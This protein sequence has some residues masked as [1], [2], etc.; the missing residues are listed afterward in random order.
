MNDAYRTMLHS[1]IERREEDTIHGN[2]RTVRVDDVLLKNDIASNREFAQP[3]RASG[4]EDVLWKRE[5]MLSTKPIDVAGLPAVCRRCET[6]YCAEHVLPILQQLRGR[7]Q[8]FKYLWCAN[9]SLI[10]AN[11]NHEILNVVISRDFIFDGSV[12][13]DTFIN[14]KT[15]RRLRK[16]KLVGKYFNACVELIAKDGA[17]SYKRISRKDIRD[18]RYYLIDPLRN[19]WCR[20]ED[21]WVRRFY[22]ERVRKFCCKNFQTAASVFNR[23][24]I[25]HICTDNF[26]LPPMWMAYSL[27]TNRIKVVD[28]RR[29]ISLMY[30]MIARW[31]RKTYA[32]GSL[33]HK[34]LVASYDGMV[35]TKNEQMHASARRH[36]RDR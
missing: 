5:A 25:Y 27:F 24:Q 32:P 10:S 1:Y 21:A 29:R 15:K 11:T 34:R 26:D 14:F 12:I 9:K 30:R 19:L 36:R 22:I 33:V 2:K 6:D 8:Y 13:T 23:R 4:T 18:R 35:F 28:V 31:K 7:D 20:V 17:C 16:Q 3:E